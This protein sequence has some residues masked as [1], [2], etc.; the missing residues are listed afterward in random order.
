VPVVIRE[1]AD[2]STTILAVVGVVLALASLGWQ[3]F[4]FYISG[5]R[6]A[7]DLRPGMTD[8]L[9]TTAVTSPGPISP[10]QLNTTQ[11][12]GFTRPTIAV[13]VRNSG[14]S[15]TNITSVSVAYDNGAT[16]SETH[17]DPSLPFRLDAESEKTWYFETGRVAAYAEAVKAARNLTR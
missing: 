16:Y 4:S 9:G 2:L 8:P 13:E 3:A 5:S 15:P 10:A 14:R 6:V 17:L 12:Q 1:S 7:V 11:R